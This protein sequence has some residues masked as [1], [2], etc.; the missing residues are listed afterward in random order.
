MIKALPIG[1]LYLAAC[2]ALWTTP[3]F[4]DEL[5]SAEIQ[6]ELIGR[7]IGWWEQ[8]GWLQGHILFSPDGSAEI[9][10]DQPRVTG[11]RGRWSI[12]GDEL[13][14]EWGEIRAAEKCYTI[15][16]GEDGRFVTSGG[17]IFQIRETGI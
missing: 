17:N 3:V 2:A 1:S 16:R 13:C 8:G 5:T 4:G 7:S 14:T 6:A 15:E 10:V 9:S 11:D 12:K